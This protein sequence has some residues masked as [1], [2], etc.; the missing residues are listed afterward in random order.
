M[1]AAREAPCVA[2]S[3][4]ARKNRLPDEPS[5]RARIRQAAP[6]Q[7]R[8]VGR[9]KPAERHMRFANLVKPVPGEAI[10]GHAGNACCSA[11]RDC[12][13]VR[14][15]WLVEPPAH[16]EIRSCGAEAGKRCKDGNS[17]YN[18]HLGFPDLVSVNETAKVRVP[19]PGNCSKTPPRQALRQSHEV[20]FTG[21][22]G[23]R[24][25]LPEGAGELILERLDDVLE[26]RAVV[27]LHED[28]R[29]HAGDELEARRAA[30]IS[31]R[32]RATRI[33]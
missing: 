1:S 18:S 28:L 7:A 29:L 33:V 32:G 13:I 5:G 3:P 10:A 15:H 8:N 17:R 20:N 6:R 9:V 4:F 23:L 21:R 22:Q 31:S 24:L 19:D 2:A 16:A 26:R 11:M 12:P 27:G 30:S 25:P 14:H